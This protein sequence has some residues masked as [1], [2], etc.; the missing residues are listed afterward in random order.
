[1]LDGSGTFF[2]SLEG[3]LTGRHGAKGV[4]PTKNYGEDEF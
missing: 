3:G 1:M 2:L 4:R